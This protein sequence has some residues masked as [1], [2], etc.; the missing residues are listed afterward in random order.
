LITGRV[1]G[2]TLQGIDTAN[3]GPGIGAGKL[4]DGP[5]VTIGDLLGKLNRLVRARYVDEITAPPSTPSAVTSGVRASFIALRR[6]VA[7]THCPG[8]SSWLLEDLSR[9]TAT[10][11]RPACGVADASAELRP[12]TGVADAAVVGRFS[13]AGIL[14]VASTRRFSAPAW[15]STSPEFAAGAGHCPASRL[16]PGP[17][18]YFTSHSGRAAADGHC[19]TGRCSAELSSRHADRS[20]GRG[21]RT[22]D[23]AY[24]GCR[25]GSVATLG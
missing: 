8:H 6:S 10:P 22:H 21:A 19:G 5:G 7:D 12:W 23:S 17:G 25:Q 20:A 4:F 15:S 24:T 9:N 3:T 16:Q 18:C 13:G 14:R 2:D 11:D 1:Q